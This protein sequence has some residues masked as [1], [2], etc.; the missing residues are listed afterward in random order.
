MLIIFSILYTWSIHLPASTL[1]TS[2][3]HLIDSCYDVSS[4]CFLLSA[5]KSDFILCS[6]QWFSKVLD[7]PVFFVRMLPDNRHDRPLEE[8]VSALFKKREKN[9]IDTDYATV[10]VSS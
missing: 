6:D 7:S 2:D 3:L 8:L 10:Q 5:R 9:N 1:Y 4:T